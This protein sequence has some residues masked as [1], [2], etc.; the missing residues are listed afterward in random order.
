MKK[1]TII[2][3][4]LALALAANAAS[5]K[6]GITECLNNQALFS[7]DY[8]GYLDPG[9]TFTLKADGTAVASAVYTSAMWD[10]GQFQN[11]IADVDQEAWFMAAGTPGVGGFV[12]AN[13]NTAFNFTIEVTT[14]IG[15]V[16]YIWS[17]SVNLVGFND[18][19]GVASSG[20]AQ[21]PSTLITLA[22]VP[23][24]T[25]MALLALG[26]AAMGLRRRFRK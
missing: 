26:A 25:A 20:F 24:P 19:Q 4:T 11:T 18:A 5:L 23:E 7:Q 8:P 14:N 21:L 16:D 15:G 1:L 13:Y 6:W 17:S 9:I 10:T 3:A 22:P 2:V 12:W